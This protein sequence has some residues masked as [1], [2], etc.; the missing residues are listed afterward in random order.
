[1][2]DAGLG[3]IRFCDELVHWIDCC[4]LGDLRTLCRGIECYEANPDQKD[5]DGRALGAGHFLLVAGCCMALDYFGYIY[6]GCGVDEANVLAYIKKFLH[7]V[8]PRY[9]EADVLM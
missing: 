8:H 6:H 9:S 2:R 7:V 5:P 3:P 1:M 4:V